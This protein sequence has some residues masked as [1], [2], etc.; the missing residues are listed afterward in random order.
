MTIE[1]PWVKASQA[2]WEQRALE[3]AQP[4]WLK[5][6][7]MAYA[8]VGA[9][10]HAG[11]DRGELAE[12]MGKGRQ[13]I[14]RAIRTAVEYGWLEVG[15]CTE[16][17]IPP[18]D[19]IEM[20]FGNSRKVCK[21]HRGLREINREAAQTFWSEGRAGALTASDVSNQSL[22]AHTFSASSS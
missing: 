20:G 11:F 12:L 1:A 7:C 5:V 16:C 14:H 9:S 22:H 4:L 2:G 18:G 15:S 8:R 3:L 21:V 13:D 6:A 10:G 19:F 17:L